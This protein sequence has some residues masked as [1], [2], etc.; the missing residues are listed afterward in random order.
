MNSDWNR[1][2]TAFEVCEDVPDEEVF[3]RNLRDWQHEIRKVHSREE[4]LQRV[5]DAPKLLQ[6]TLN[7]HGQCDAYLASYVEWLSDIAGV[8]APGWVDQSERFA[9]KAWY[10]F[11]ECWWISFLQSPRAFRRHGVF[12]SPDNVLNI[13][14]G[15]PRKSAK[16]K[17]ATNA[18]RQKRYRQR[19]KAKLARLQELQESVT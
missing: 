15:R 6:P 4:F 5:V 17:R 16:E 8:E 18:A 9:T 11:P 2:L 1:P 14:P 13:R 7:D 19:V 10:D 12:T 3:G